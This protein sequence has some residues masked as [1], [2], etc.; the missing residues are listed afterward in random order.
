MSII[1]QQ[2][3]SHLLAFSISIF[4]STALSS[5]RLDR[6]SSFSICFS[7]FP[8]YPGVA[9]NPIARAFSQHLVS[10]SRPRHWCFWLADGCIAEVARH[11]L[12]TTLEQDRGPALGNLARQP[13]CNWGSPHG[14]SYSVTKE[15]RQ[16]GLDN[17]QYNVVTSS[18]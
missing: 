15:T 5:D 11:A 7:L 3:Q 6:D 16:R 4:Q 1:C 2:T 18:Y 13:C 12:H 17:Q 9:H 10:T 8:L 14:K